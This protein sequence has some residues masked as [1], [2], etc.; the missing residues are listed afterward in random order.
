MGK[1]VLFIG[2]QFGLPA[3]NSLTETGHSLTVITGRPKPSGRGQKSLPNP[4]SLAAIRAGATLIEVGSAQELIQATANIQADAGL[5]VSFG[6]MIPSVVLSRF[7]QPIINI[8]PSLLP[9]WRGASP[10]EATILAGDKQTGVS[11]IELTEELDAGPI[12]AQKMVFLK[13]NENRLQLFALLSKLGAQLFMDN[14]GKILSDET[15]TTPQNED[16]ATYTHKVNK[17]EGQLDWEKSADELERQ[18]RAYLGRPGSYTDIAGHRITVLSAT[19]SI[20]SGKPGTAFR[21]GELLGI[22]CRRGSLIL[23][24][25]QPAGGRA[26][27]SSA[28]LNGH[29]DVL[30]IS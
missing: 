25:I 13:G 9:R 17:Q 23:D 16:D 29:P 30:D 6:L 4:I 24:Q 1:L 27:S 15:H 14:L 7:R 11:L 19:S 21:Q 12:I 26:M 22:Y 28:F 20:E 10:I 2:D 8:H 3:L 18:V 5:L